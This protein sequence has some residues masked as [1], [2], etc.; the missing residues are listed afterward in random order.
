MPPVTPVPLYIPP[1]GA[2]PERGKAGA[3][4]HTGLRAENVTTGIGRNI[5]IAVPETVPLQALSETDKRVYVYVPE[6]TALIT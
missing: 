1:A 3:V 4:T 2:P 6:P 5:T